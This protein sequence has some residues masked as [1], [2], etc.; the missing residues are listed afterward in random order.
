MAGKPKPE[1]L[2]KSA[3]IVCRMRTDLRHQLEVEA[4]ETGETISAV[5]VRRLLTSYD[6]L[7]SGE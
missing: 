3:T 6:A 5:V 4:N 2:R 1:E 7:Y